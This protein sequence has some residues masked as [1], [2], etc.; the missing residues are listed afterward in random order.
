MNLESIFLRNYIKKS[1]FNEVRPFISNLAKAL[2]SY[3]N[4]IGTTEYNAL[5]NPLK[6]VQDTSLTCDKFLN[7]KLG[8]NPCPKPEELKKSLKR[9]I[10]LILEKKGDKSISALDFLLKAMGPDYQIELPLNHKD[11]KRYHFSVERVFDAFFNL[12]DPELEINNRMYPII[13][14]DTLL[15]KRYLKWYRKNNLKKI[16]AE[17]FQKFNSIERVEFI[18]RNLAFDDYNILVGL[19][20]GTAFQLQTRE[21]LEKV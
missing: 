7:T 3:G 6:E 18:L 8:H 19:A 9:L 17:Y 12:S 21:S 5:M 13:P 20:N 16:N 4:W 1:N 15:A 14:K 11:S 10:T 2:K